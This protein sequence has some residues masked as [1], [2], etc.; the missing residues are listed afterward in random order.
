[1]LNR[2]CVNPLQEKTNN[3]R[4]MALEAQDEFDAARNDAKKSASASKALIKLRGELIRLYRM[5][6]ELTAS[7]QSDAERDMTA[8]L[9]CDL[10]QISKSAHEAVGFTYAPLEQL[11]A[12]Q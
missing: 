5:Q 8:M 9:L 10:E 7:V 1:V 3:I 2:L 11:A 12:L 6:Q 4:S